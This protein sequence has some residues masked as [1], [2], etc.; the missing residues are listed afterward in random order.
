MQSVRVSQLLDDAKILP[1]SST[2]SIWCNNVA[3]MQTDLRQHKM[4]VT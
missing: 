4:N 2:L 1:K 3:D